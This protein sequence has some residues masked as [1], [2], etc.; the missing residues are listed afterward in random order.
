MNR[1]IS[2]ITGIRSG[3]LERRL[4]VYSRAKLVSLMTGESSVQDTV[5]RNYGKSS[6]LDE[7]MERLKKYSISNE[8]H[9][10]KAVCLA[11]MV[12]D[13]TPSHEPRER[14]EAACLA[15]TCSYYVVG[16]VCNVVMV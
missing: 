2:F 12:H 4:K 5:S 8:E 11:L 3:D 10:Y 15:D 13:V 14:V 16:T 7:L 6:V 9:T 1:A